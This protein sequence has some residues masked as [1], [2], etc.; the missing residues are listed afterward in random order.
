MKLNRT[1][2]SIMRAVI[3]MTA[4]V[5]FSAACSFAVPEDVEPGMHTVD[6]SF[7]NIKS[8]TGMI[9]ISLCTKEQHAKLGQEPCEKS[10]RIDAAEGA[11]LSFENVPSGI[12]VISAFHD[13]N[14]NQAL[15]FDTRGIPFEPTGNSG[16]AKGF[17]GPPSFDQMKFRLSGDGQAT[18]KLIS[19]KMSTVSVP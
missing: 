16:N 11:S 18:P 17:F 2:P 1:Q 14:D 8:D 7:T 5:G 3:A 4:A 12:Y 10:A 13:A 9:W 15:D 6:V 19:I